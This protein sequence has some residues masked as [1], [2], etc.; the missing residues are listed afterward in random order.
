MFQ[1]FNRTHSFINDEIK[2]NVGILDA[3][4]GNLTDTMGDNEIITGFKIPTDDDTNDKIKDKIKEKLTTSNMGNN[5]NA[6]GLNSSKNNTH[7]I[8]SNTNGDKKS[9]VMSNLDDG[10]QTVNTLCH[11]LLYNCGEGGGEK[12]GGGQL[13][14]V[15]HAPPPVYMMG[16]DR[17]VMGLSAWKKRAMIGLDHNVIGLFPWKK[18]SNS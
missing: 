17:N 16:L 11:S 18:R 8:N 6:N 3:L 10:K 2:L 12:G 5:I 4:L 14:V 9:K 7:D 1:C 13:Q 15:T